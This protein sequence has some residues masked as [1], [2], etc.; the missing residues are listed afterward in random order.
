MP[1]EVKL[2]ARSCI[3]IETTKKKILAGLTCFVFLSSERVISSVKR[4]FRGG[5]T[6]TVDG[7]TGEAVAKASTGMGK[8]LPFSITS[9]L[10]SSTG[11]IAFECLLREES[12]PLDSRSVVIAP[13]L[14]K[15]RPS[16]NDFPKLQQ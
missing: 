7:D 1:T 10:S 14:M 16:C 4:G 2:H 6:S 3:M 12:A 13:G 9:C 11:V 15:L 5:A 8:T